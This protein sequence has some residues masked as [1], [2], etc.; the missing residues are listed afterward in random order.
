LFSQFGEYLLAA[1]DLDE[2]RDPANAAD[3]RIVPFLEINRRLRPAAN[4]PRHLAKA[5]FI[6]P[7]KLFRL[8]RRSG[9]SADGANH[10]ENAG[11]VTLIERMDGNASADQLCR[12]LRLEIGKGENEI[13][14]ERED[15]RNVGRSEGRNA[16]LPS[17]DLGGRTA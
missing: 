6:A 9:Q 8:I 7:G 13:G 16:R 15:F 11:D 2:F 5:S 14:L 17:P 3:E 10:R 1:G 12:D 4:Q